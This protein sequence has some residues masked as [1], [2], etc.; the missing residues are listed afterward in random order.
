MFT[1]TQAIQEFL[2]TQTCKLDVYSPSLEVQVNVVPNSDGVKA[3][4]IPY[5]GSG[6]DAEPYYHDSILDFD[7]ANYVEA[8]GVT[9][10][11][12]QSRLSRWVGFDFDSI[13]NHTVG[14]TDLE[15]HELR[16]QCKLIPWV[17]LRRSKSG[18][19]YHLYVTF[20][21]PVSTRNHTEHAALAT[22]VLNQLSS[23]LSFNF[24]EKVDTAG[25]VLWIWHKQADPS[26]QSFQLVKKADYPLDNIPTNWKDYL[27]RKRNPVRKTNRESFKDLHSKIRRIPLSAEHKK[28]LVWLANQENTWWWDD[29]YN[30]LVTHTVTLK[31]GHEELGLRGL[32]DTKATGKDLPND[33]NCFAFPLRDGGWC[34]YRY[35]PRCEEHAVWSISSSGWTHTNYNTLPDLNTVARLYGGTKTKRGYWIFS[36]ISSVHSVLRSLGCNV[37]VPDRFSNRDI[38]IQPGKADNELVLRI[39]YEDGDRPLSDWYIDGKPR[40]W[41]T[42]VTCNVETKLVEPPDEIVRHVSAIDGKS[43]WY[44]YTRGRWVPK[45]KDDIK[46]A[47]RALDYNGNDIENLLGTAVLEDWSEVVLPFQTEYPGDRQWNRDAPQLAVEPKFGKHPHWDRIFNHLGTNIPVDQNEWCRTFNIETGADYLKLWASCLIRHPFDPLP[48]LFFYSVDQDTGKSMFHEALSLLF[49]DKNGYTM[50]DQSLTDKNGFNG[51]LKGAVLCAVE[52]VDLSKSTTAYNRIKDWVTSRTIYIR[53]LHKRGANFPNSTHWIQTA[54]NSS[55]CPIFPGDTRIVAIAVNKLG[56]LIPKGELEIHLRNELP[57]ITNT[58]LRMSIPPTNSRLRIPIV[59]TELKQQV[60]ETNRNRVEEFI[61]ES[62]T[63]ESGWVIDSDMFI[64][65]FHRSMD[66]IEAMQWP[67]KLV[68]DSIPVGRIVK[69]KYGAGSKLHL[70]NIRVGDKS[71]QVSNSHIVRVNGRLKT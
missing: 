52:E 35:S 57:Y 2:K 31:K 48:Y 27:E 14:L 18:R 42:V 43:E 7:L 13:F 5:A 50:A 6:P 1:K 12:W 49:K 24:S 59:D 64:D 10:W 39:K 4:R 54:N 32:Y 34:V 58:L 22:A 63:V 45:G 8:I 47:L 51:E 40:H 17:E 25:T 44:V 9:G 46:S 55:Y 3:F 53:D 38:T 70:G 69:G 67:K 29:D 11:D 36:N 37:V 41:E 66:S 68:L 26:N 33:H 19:G 28:L 62:C 15:L 65:E 71:R 23:L 16:L 30:M 60:S 20:K 56:E 61:E 21:N